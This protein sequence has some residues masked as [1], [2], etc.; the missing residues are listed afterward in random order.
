VQD[1]FHALA[2]R[3]AARLGPAEAAPAEVRPRG[4]GMLRGLSR[5]WAGRRVPAGSLAAPGGP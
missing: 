2:L 1:Q 4:R 5:L 3:H